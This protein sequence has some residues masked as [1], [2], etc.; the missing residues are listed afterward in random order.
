MEDKIPKKITAFKIIGTALYGLTTVLMAIL[1]IAS[2]PEDD[3]WDKLGYLLVV[4]VFC[5][6]ALI[7]YVA[8]TVFGILGLIFTKKQVP[9][10][11]KK[12]NKIYFILMTALPLITDL[13]FFS[14]IFLLGD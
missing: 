3:G 2:I 8:A 9:E 13:L 4:L 7:P 1:L 6:W 12:G 11:K 14:T 5:L 10:E